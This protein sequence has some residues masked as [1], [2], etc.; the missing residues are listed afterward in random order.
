MKSRCTDILGLTYRC[1]VYVR[2]TTAESARQ[3]HH[4]GLD[5]DSSLNFVRKCHK[6]P[7]SPGYCQEG[8]RRRL[9]RRGGICKTCAAGSI[10]RENRVDENKATEGGAHQSSSASIP[11]KKTVALHFGQCQTPCTTAAVTVDIH[12]TWPKMC[13]EQWTKRAQPRPQKSSQ[14]SHLLAA[15]QATACSPRRHRQTLIDELI[16]QTTNQH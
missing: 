15:Q 5:S 8:D 10:D 4:L 16:P 6:S 1:T 11:T 13:A 9:S 7:A 2:A 14:S 3:K 12:L